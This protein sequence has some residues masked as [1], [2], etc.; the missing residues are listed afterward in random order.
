[1]R[2]LQSIRTKLVL[3]FLALSITPLAILTYLNLT[4]GVG[5][6]VLKEAR[7]R[8]METIAAHKANQLVRIFRRLRR[9]MRIAQDDP[10]ISS[11]LSVVERLLRDRGDPAYIDAHRRLDKQLQILQRTKQLGDVLLVSL[12][13]KIVYAS[14]RA[15]EA[16]K[17]G[18]PLPGPRGTA[19]QESR[20]GICYSDV[21]RNEMEGNVLEFLVTGPVCNP[22]GEVIGI[23]AF[24][25]NMDLILA[26]VEDTS[27]LGDTGETVVAR[28]ADGAALFLVPLR[29]DPDA[30]L[31][32]RA[33]YGA[34]VALPIQEATRG[35]QGSGLS[36]D[37]RGEPVIAAWR[38]IPSCDWGLVTKIDQKEA[39]AVVR[40]LRRIVLT[41]APAIALVVLLAA[42]LF[43]A[44]LTKPIIDLTA[45]ARLI[46]GENLGRVVSATSGDEVGDL[47]LAF[48][49]M[50]QRLRET[51]VSRDALQA[52]VAER[53]RAEK[54]L[55]EAQAELERRVQ[56]RTAE[57]DKRTA[58]A[59]QLNA[60][61][62]NLLEDL[63]E[64]NRDLGLTTRDLGA[65]NREL[66]A[67]SYSVSHDLRS[68]LRG[69]DGYTRILLEDYA[70]KLGDDGLSMLNTI[71]DSVAE[72]AQLI[73]DLLE[74]SRLG[75]KDM[76]VSNIDMGQLATEVFRKAQDAA[77]TSGR[78]LR[79][80]LDAL[81]PA[82]GD[83]SMVR[84]VFAN[85]MTNAIKFT[86]TRDVS[87]IE[88]GSLPI[89]Q[90]PGGPMSSAAASPGHN[91]IT[92][93]VR[94]NGVGFDMTY[95]D[96]LFQVFQRLHRKEDFEG[97]GIGLA[98]VQRIIHRH[99][100]RVWAQGEVDNGATF[101]FTLPK[102]TEDRE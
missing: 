16:E 51:T 49:E 68:P 26:V 3:L 89:D 99:G 102:A 8:E 5:K 75:R 44:T 90:L 41:T 65:S 21:F 96:K 69:I 9:D 34:H 20:T 64:S 37:Y 80:Q 85:L 54:S 2:G 33:V 53:E 76:T 18:N 62:V 36:V 43:S 52:E 71:V 35:R 82:R 81:P 22:K 58:E 61:M 47:A 1:M 63:Q 78:E 87:V 6:D 55:R 38:H 25:V 15:T 28:K 60:G 94:D 95:A 86:G 7:L 100:G 10:S 40:G 59:E 74:F 4:V 70:D 50:T 19:L 97:T 42:L 29:H 27:G 98:L 46:G 67:F 48:N 11:N 13:G 17:L 12:R 23:L 72:M 31:K 83:R 66:E 45:S 91:E 30:T 79:L 84:E 93:F 101:Y 39:F 14:N 77:D 88:V 73:D 32:R 24:E 92:Y 57:L 56:Q